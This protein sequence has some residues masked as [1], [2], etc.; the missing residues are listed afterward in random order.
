MT[1]GRERS[2]QPKR[3]HKPDDGE[4]PVP[5]TIEAEL[6]Q[7]IPDLPREKRELVVSVVREHIEHSGPLPSPRTLA[8]YDQI[9]PGFA[10]RIVGMAERDLAH[11]QDMQ[12]AALHAEAR[13]RLIGQLGAIATILGALGASAWMVTSGFPWPGGLIG[14]ATLIGIVL[15]LIGGKEY[16]LAK[17]ERAGSRGA[18]KP[19]A[20]NRRKKR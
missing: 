13:E 17:L 15:G 8:D 6:Q 11:I 5:Q 16:L 1:E 12:K 7:K 3:D 14:G 18:P 4:P 20:V 19:P 9:S 10:E 2:R